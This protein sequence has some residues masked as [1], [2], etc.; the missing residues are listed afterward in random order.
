MHLKC[1]T[2]KIA[3]RTLK[4]LAQGKA[5]FVGV[6]WTTEV[7]VHFLPWMPSFVTKMHVHVTS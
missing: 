1:P 7:D 2:L 3:W 5:W 4:L 6:L